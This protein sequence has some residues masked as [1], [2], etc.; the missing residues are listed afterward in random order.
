[1]DNQYNID[2]LEPA[3]RK[4]VIKNGFQLFFR[5]PINGFILAF[6]VG[7]CFFSSYLLKGTPF[8][9]FLPILILPFISFSI[10]HANDNN[11]NFWNFNIQN[12]KFIPI[13]HIFFQIGFI[14]FML[15]LEIV[16]IVFSNEEATNEIVEESVKSGFMEV[17]IGLFIFLIVPVLFSYLFSI[18]NFNSMLRIYCANKWKITHLN[19][20]ED[21]KALL[22]FHEI[23]EGNLRKNLRFVF[24]LGFV[25]FFISNI[26]SAFFIQS[27]EIYLIF[28]SFVVCILHNILYV[29]IK[30]ICGD[31]GI[32]EKETQKVFKQAEG[33]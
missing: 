22:S 12:L 30:N 33:M 9:Y 13:Q 20:K 27:T 31:G 19:L 3:E 32:N 21:F 10:C 16:K 17:V 5:R 2:K 1:V 26:I 24:L 6:F 25:L 23:V 15:L 11:N 14:I 28:I 7:I 18:L 8:I 4:N 29:I